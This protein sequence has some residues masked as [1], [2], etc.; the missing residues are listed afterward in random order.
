MSIKPSHLWVLDAPLCPCCVLGPRNWATVLNRLSTRRS[1][2]EVCPHQILDS[3]RLHL[4]LRLV[5]CTKAAKHCNMIYSCGKPSGKWSLHLY[6]NRSWLSPGRQIFAGRGTECAGFVD[7]VQ[8]IAWMLP[9][10]TD[11]LL[12]GEFYAFLSPRLSPTL[13]PRSASLCLANSPLNPG[14]PFATPDSRTAI[15]WTYRTRYLLP[16]SGL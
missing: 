9:N 7:C 2:L 1:T 13:Q 8:S 16:S 10:S 6:L 5:C 3:S 15:R 11:F 4:I 12:F 14:A